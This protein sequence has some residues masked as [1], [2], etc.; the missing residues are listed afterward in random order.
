MPLNS[1]TPAEIELTERRRLEQPLLLLVWLSTAAFSLAEGNLWYLL[2]CTLAVG[3]NLIAVRRHKEVFVNKILVN[4]GVLLSAGI[5][6][7]EFRIGGQSS[8][9]PL[10]HFMVLL[11][12]CKLFEKKRNRD[13]SQLLTLSLVLMIITAMLSLELWFAL[14]LML[15]LV[16]LS[17]VTMILNIKR[18]LD[19]AAST[20]LTS[21][22]GPLSPKRIAWNVIRRWPGRPI[23]RMTSRILIPSLIIGILAFLLIP[24]VSKGITRVL[25]NVGLFSE[26]DS[27]LRLGGSKKLYQS[28]RVVMRVKVFQNGKSGPAP[29]T[30]STYLRGNIL[31]GYSDSKWSPVS[32]HFPPLSYKLSAVDDDLMAQLIHHEIEQLALTQTNPVGPYPTV[33]ISGSDGAGLGVSHDGNFS[34]TGRD[35][36]GAAQRYIT[37]SFGQPLTPKQRQY[38]KQFERDPRSTMSPLQRVKLPVQAGKKIDALAHRWTQDL[39]AKRDAHPES[40]DDNNLRIARRIAQ[41]LMELYPYSLDLSDSDPTRDGVEDFLFHMKKG[42]CEY[43]AS[44]LAVMCNRLDIPARVVTGFVLNEYDPETQEYTVREKDAH[45]WC[46]IYHPKKGWVLVDPTPGNDRIESMKQGWWAKVKNLWAELRFLWVAKVVSYDSATQRDISNQVIDKTLEA[47]K[48]FSEVCANIW[49]SFLNLLVHGEVDQI[50]LDF[51]WLFL[52]ISGLVG[53]WM[54]GRRMYHVQ[55]MQK[56]PEYVASMR[57]LSALQKLIE[58]M[59]R[60]GYPKSR[61]QTLR[62]YLSSASDQFALPADVLEQMG[63][64]QNRWRWGLQAPD[65]EELRNVQR[66][67][68]RLNEQLKQARKV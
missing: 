41:K 21:E 31:E 37:G 19:R 53:L 43:F 24:R 20:K 54:V 55:K 63:R 18:G 35:N 25:G 3:V 56:D 58:T 36:H 6:L 44:A 16:L 51:F 38:M 2:G 62:N 12:L 4:V 48:K 8:L 7:M 27:S 23:F 15:Y 42:H 33:A 67:C 47:G 11:Q 32:A 26:Q 46:E 10:G 49:E 30:E 29:F 9:I 60:S 68:N 13:Y 65:I 39:L 14:M 5:V 40:T 50:L 52:A 17:Y 45:A 22:S 61:M 59:E 66:Q 28:P 64:L 1:F 34:V 57:K